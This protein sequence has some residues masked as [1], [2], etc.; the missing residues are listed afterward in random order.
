MNICLLTRMMPSHSQGGVQDHTEMLA[1]GLAGRG[2]AVTILTTALSG[3]PDREERGGVVIRYLPG[4]TPG[5]LDGSWD[6]MS[7]RALEASHREV[8]FDLI[9]SQGPAGYALLKSDLHGRLKIPALI[10]FHGT[11]Y[12]ELVTRA[13][14][15]F[16]CNPWRTAK[17]GAAIGIVLGKMLGDYRAIPHA[18]GVIAT[19]NEQA[20]I[21]ERVYRVPRGRIHTVFNGVDLGGFTPGL[22]PEGM[23]ERLGLEPG[24]KV[25]LAVARLIRDKGIQ[26]AIAALP[27]IRGA[28]PA[29]TLVVVGDGGYRPALERM[30]RNAGPVR[31]LGSVP[32]GELPDYFRLCDLFLNATVQQNG[33]DL[34]MVEAMACGKVVVSSNIGS[35]PTLIEDGV[36]G[37]LF[38]T[39]DRRSL[40]RT[41]VGILGDEG[42]RAAMGDRARRKVV[43]EF[44][45]DA[46]VERT[47]AVYRTLLTRA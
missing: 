33:Y 34:T 31:F 17:N 24:G 6:R 18:D 28:F 25:L 23:R 11:H 41:V 13:R 21:L 19:S 47:I 16:S 7:R 46:M 4:T 40:A 14:R 30:A 9:H 12:D 5:A 44:T 27:E 45:L 43:S 15:G 8:P 20:V 32:F 42:A 1:A 38:P 37:L 35:T 29:C 36:D 3:G 10:S 26:H 39:A 22:P 2:H